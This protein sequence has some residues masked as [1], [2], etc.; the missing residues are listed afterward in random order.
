MT[1]EPEIVRLLRE[2][3][4]AWKKHAAS[5]SDI[6]QYKPE[7]NKPQSDNPP[8]NTLFPNTVEI[9]NLEE[10]YKVIF[11]NSA[12]AI[13]L[14]DEQERII[15]W[16]KYAETL[17]NM[18]KEDLFLT[19]IKNLY[20]S[21]EWEKIRREHIRQKGM[22][23]HLETK[24][25]R[26]NKEP[27]NVDISL[28]VLRNQKGEIIGSIG[29]IKDITVQKKLEQYL[30][31]T[32]EKFENLYENAPI[33]Y[34][35]LSPEGIITNVNEKWCQNLGYTKKEVIGKSI[36]DF[37]N[38]H[39]KKKAQHSFEKKF[40]KK[41]QYVEG[42]ERLYQT[43]SG[44][45]KIFMIHD[46]F[47]YDSNKNVESIHTVMEDI[48]QRKHTENELKKE[49]NFISTLVQASPAYF[50]AINKDGNVIMM[51]NAMLQTLQYSLEEIRGK[52]YLTNFVPKK[53]YQKLEKIFQKLITTQ[54]PALTEN[55]IQ[56][57]NGDIRLV[58]W[59]GRPVFKQNGEFDFFFGMG[60][61]IT[62][63]KIA[64][65]E[66]KKK[67]HELEEFALELTKTN[68]Q[69][70]SAREQLTI[71]NK[72]LEKKVKYRTREVEQL[73]KQKDEFISQLGHD[74]KTP[75]T[76]L[77]NV[78]PNLEEIDDSD[79]KKDCEV[80]I[81]NVNYIKNLVTDTLTIAELSSPKVQLNLEPINIH[82]VIEKAIQYKQL[83]STKENIIFEN[84]IK[85]TIQ[86]HVDKL[87]LEE[88]ITNLVSNAV[89]FINSPKGK[90]TFTTDISKDTHTTIII[91][92]NGIGM[93][94]EQINRIFDEFYKADK[95]RHYLDSVGLGLSIC[96]RIIELHGGKIWA[97]SPGPNKGS[98]FKFTIPNIKTYA[99]L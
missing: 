49:R 99:K 71:L 22:Q 73:L 20:P 75:L 53:E 86:I 70:Q 33:A 38:P 80:A 30:K 93:T 29:V 77:I 90:I 45:K 72:Y 83:E 25:M 32:K 79:L 60:I 59:H 27:L 26:K 7:K 11:E 48:T 35:T 43:K 31:E 15:S 78:L 34:H 94:K 4:K 97:E 95:S 98:T 57:K 52:H 56:A 74:L 63:R 44:E 91:T 5:I 89:K 61:D 1:T 16:N 12:V 36:F 58:E 76:I 14:T 47:Q 19:P 54:K 23:H 37:I 82:D 2:E 85:E 65:E 88:V 3:E 55:H 66:I 6:Q 81:R 68:D 64:E 8:N 46:F 92:D 41:Q 69:L 84:K 50:V 87:R 13:T 67:N 9:K 17:L 39:E 51:N 62:Q 28:S 10:V 42:S 96:K 40:L 18:Q 21:E 24:I